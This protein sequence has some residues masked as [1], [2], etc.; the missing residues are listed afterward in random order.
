[1]F[2]YL[3]ICEQIHSTAPW[4]REKSKTWNSLKHPEMEMLDIV[5][6]MVHHVVTLVPNLS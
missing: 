6:E 5:L 3:S 4:S 2:P 1:M